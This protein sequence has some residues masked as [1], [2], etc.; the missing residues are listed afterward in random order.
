MAQPDIIDK[1]NQLMQRRTSLSEAE[2]TYLF[3]QIRK[4]LDHE[5]VNNNPNEYRH[6][7]FYCDW[8]VHISKDRID[9]S[10]LDVLKD[11]E[12]GVKKMVGNRNHHADGPINFA[13]FES[14]RAEAIDFLT[15]QQIAHNAF[16]RQ[17]LW[18]NI[19]DKLVR[20]LENQPISI[21]PA[22]GMLIQTLEFLPS[23]P[24]TVW[25]RAVFNTA[26]IGTDGKKYGYFDLKNVY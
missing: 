24:G 1:L 4:L 19:I 13:Y 22:H 14:L 5:R 21:S 11:F 23:A 9:T 12:L 18:I 26:L 25:I 7:R 20:I 6:L 16:A 17:E 10:T 3:V 2:V 15:A 8:I